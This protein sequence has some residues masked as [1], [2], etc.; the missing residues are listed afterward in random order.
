MSLKLKNLRSLA[1]IAVMIFV[2]TMSYA[3]SSQFGRYVGTLKHNSIQKEQLVKIDF[4]TSRSDANEIELKAVLTLQFGDFKSGEYISYHFDKVLFNLLAGTL[5]FDQAEEDVTVTTTRF[6][7]GEFVGQLRSSA[8]G[9]VGELKLKLNTAAAPTLPLIEPVNG[10]YAGICE[11]N[12]IGKLQLHTMRSTEDTSRV[13]N[14]F[15]TYEIKGQ[16]GY[17]DDF[18]CSGIG[19]GSRACQRL[20]VENA[21]YNFYSGELVVIG[22]LQTWTCRVD[23]KG[24]SCDNGCRFNRISSER[25][26]REFLPPQAQAAFIAN[27]GEAPALQGAVAG[28]AGTYKGFVHHEYQDRYQPIQVSLVTYQAQE[29]GESN[30]RL[31]ATANLYFGDLGT[32]EFL[33]YR[34]EP[35]D[36]P[37]PLTRPQFT[38]SRLE[39]DVDAFLKITSIE[40]GI[41]KGEWH[42]LLFGRVGTFEARKEAAG[43]VQIA[44]GSKRF[45]PMSAFYDENV[46]EMNLKVFHGSTP[47][48]TENPFFPLNIGG[49]FRMKAGG[50]REGIK[51]GSYDFYTGKI[52]FERN[53]DRW[54]IGHRPDNSRFYMRTI[55]N[56][57]GSVMQDFINPRVFTL[58][59][60]PTNQ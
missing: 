56:V 35:R 11:D 15:G 23:E 19:P 12:K 57:Y 5:V 9:E 33:S 41:I 17:V 39:D 16:F 49:W 48:N 24:M 21:S 25:S 30:L 47:P 52:G 40:N 7:N 38:L 43:L 34:F 53:D 50:A 13:G 36:Y 42:S 31:S 58:T 18:I 32:S 45:Q 51:G 10:E 14:P 26:S 8:F 2:S 3:Q 29:N 55:S 60:S 1:A 22:D 44:S 54:T 6:S 37:N 46:F 4:V 59:T 28:I 27:N 20:A